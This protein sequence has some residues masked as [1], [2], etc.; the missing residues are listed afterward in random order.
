M[1]CNVGRV[2][3]C[4]V[5][6]GNDLMAKGSVVSSSRA[7]GTLCSNR[8]VK[9]RSAYLSLRQLEMRESTW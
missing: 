1:V 3:E 5:C 9:T 4:W 8:L 7:S 2:L 6:I